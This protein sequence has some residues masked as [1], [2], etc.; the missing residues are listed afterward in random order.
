MP[1][2]F[3]IYPV[4]FVGFIALE[5]AQAAIV[6]DNLGIRDSIARGWKLFRSNALVVSVLMLILYFGMSMLS[7]VI[8]F[9]MMIPMM[10]LPFS[11]DSSGNFNGTFLTFLLV[12]FPIMMAVMFI[13]QGILMAFFQSAWVVAYLRLTRAA[14][15]PVVLSE[16]NA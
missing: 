11:M 8:V 1:F 5:L 2:F 12:F 7:S 4:A 3:L 15:A 13:V 6:A 16:A 14:D 9:P 10:S